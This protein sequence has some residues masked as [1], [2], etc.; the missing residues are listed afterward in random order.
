MAHAL[1][2]LIKNKKKTKPKMMGRDLK[3]K[4]LWTIALDAT[5]MLG[6]STQLLILQDQGPR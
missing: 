3:L 6:F 1:W 2:E 4:Q 5:D